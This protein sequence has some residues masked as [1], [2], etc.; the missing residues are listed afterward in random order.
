MD[1]AAVRKL[2]DRHPK[3]LVPRV[4]LLV[5]RERAHAF[6]ERG[7]FRSMGRTRRNLNGFV[8][9][10]AGGLFMKTTV[11][12]EIKLDVAACLY[13]IAAILAVLI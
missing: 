5:S 12:I 8:A 9:R 13:G 7:S 4:A 2:G 6:H 11:K 10:R 1:P 3:Q